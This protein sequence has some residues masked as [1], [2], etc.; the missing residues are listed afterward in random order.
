[1]GAVGQ[2]RRT[3]AQ[4]LIGGGGSDQV[5]ERVRGHF[6]QI[7]HAGAATHAESARAGRLLQILLEA[8]DRGGLH[9]EEAGAKREKKCPFG[10]VVLHFRGISGTV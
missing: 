3:G 7:G 10:R 5:G 1:M 9:G 4:L 8:V 2:R 6:V